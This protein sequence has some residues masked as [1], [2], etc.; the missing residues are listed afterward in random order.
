MVSTQSPPA[1]P[2]VTPVA[3]DLNWIRLQSGGGG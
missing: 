1:A 3:D 2:L